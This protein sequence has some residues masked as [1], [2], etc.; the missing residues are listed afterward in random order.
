M[1]LVTDPCRHITQSVVGIQSLWILGHS[2]A[3]CEAMHLS[4]SG[5]LPGLEYSS[6]TELFLPDPRGLVTAS[7]LAPSGV[8]G[9]GG[10]T[11]A[12][13]ILHSYA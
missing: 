3:V 1:I 5:F 12:T 4:R 6:R 13:L 11:D 9:A 8:A 2:Q 10:D 7:G